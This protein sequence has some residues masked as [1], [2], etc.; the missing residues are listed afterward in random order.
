M[1]KLIEVTIPMTKRNG[2]WEGARVESG[3]FKHAIIADTVADVIKQ[4][5]AE[6]AKTNLESPDG[7]EGV[8]NFLLNVPDDALPDA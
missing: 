4:G 1:K 2:R 5:F 8:I 7:S 6:N 3:S